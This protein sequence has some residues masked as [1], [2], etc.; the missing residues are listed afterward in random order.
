MKIGY[1]SEYTSN[2]IRNRIKKSGLPICPVFL[3]GRKLKDIFSK[4][5]PFDTPEC[6]LGNPEKCHICPLITDGKSCT[7]KN[8][9]YRV[10]CLFC[11]AAYGGE[12]L[13]FGHD[14]FCEHLR[15]ANNP[16][17]Y[18]VNAI[19]QH[20]EKYHKGCTAR[21][22]FKIVK[23]FKYKANRK[24]SECLY[25]IREGTKINNKEELAR[26]TNFLSALF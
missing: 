12:T 2:S 24:I 4:S 21:L 7:I 8:F 3:P 19:G 13:R 17:K 11:S 15:A 22:S 23:W 25:I 16:A 5:R 1:I 18:P 26:L 6:K 14:R 9:L 20:Y 10:T